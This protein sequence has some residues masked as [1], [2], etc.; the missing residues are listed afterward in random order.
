[1]N[2]DETDTVNGSVDEPQADPEVVF[3]E[4]VREVDA[5]WGADEW[6]RSVLERIETARRVLHALRGLV[7]EAA[8]LL[9]ALLFFLA[10][11]AQFW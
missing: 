7:I 1:M 10:V 9:A 4:K 5:H 3:P 6:S 8:H 2:D 11:A